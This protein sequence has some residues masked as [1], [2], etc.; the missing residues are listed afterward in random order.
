MVV[1]QHDVTLDLGPEVGK[2]FELPVGKAFLDTSLPSWYSSAFV[3]F[4]QCST[5]F[6]FTT[7]RDWFHSPAGLIGLP[8]AGANTS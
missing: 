4:N 8:A 3:P 2:S 6:P 7:T 5:R 1:R